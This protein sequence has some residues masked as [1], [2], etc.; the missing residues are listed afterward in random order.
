MIRSLL[1]SLFLLPVFCISFVSS[2]S[3]ENIKNIS[4]GILAGQKS[5]RLQVNCPCNVISDSK[6]L[7]INAKASIEILPANHGFQVNGTYLEGT[8]LE[9]KPADKK[10]ALATKIGEKSYRGNMQIFQ[11]KDRLNVINLIS[12]EDYLR[13]V[14]S[15]EMPQSWHAEAL[16]AQ[17]VAAR[18]FV[19]YSKETGHPHSSEGYDVCATSHCQVYDGMAGERPETDAVI[20][21]TAGEVI[22]GN[23]KVLFAPFHSDSGGM[24]ESNESVWGS[25]L[26]YLQPAEELRKGT[27][28][29]TVTADVQ[30]KLGIGA[31]K[32]F[33]LSPLSIGKGAKD[34]TASGR[35]K[36]IV[37]VGNKGRKV[38]SG[39]N[40]RSMLGLKSTL[41]DLKLV[42]G[43]VQV[44]GYGSGHG[45]GMSQYGAKA[46]AEKGYDYRKI[47][48]HY[49]KNVVVQ[50]IY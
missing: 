41:F 42:K 33:E 32:K 24:T 25:K 3:A 40:F 37:F 29:W 35:V 43:K 11:K 18:S 1:L 16:K 46:F 38:V 2:C 45:V 19:L 49:F 23:G 48:E 14:V 31:I 21:A 20:K 26:F 10:A 27:Q 44:N 12:A 6:T 15:K 34:R 22:Y 47:L 13:G 39:G 30:S 9:I 5:A 28:P 8:K 50:K 36:S 4:V 7:K 17:T